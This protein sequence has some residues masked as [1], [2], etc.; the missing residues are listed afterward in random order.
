MIV[1]RVT[2]KAKLDCIDKIVQ[3]FKEQQYKPDQVKKCRAYT[4]YISQ[5]DEVVIEFEYEN[6]AEFEKASAEMWSQPEAA[7]WS[8]AWYEKFRELI[9]P[10]GFFEVWKVEEI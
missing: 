5:G 3:S 9:E 2:F 8:V 6:L 4:P 10:G 1:Y 7:A